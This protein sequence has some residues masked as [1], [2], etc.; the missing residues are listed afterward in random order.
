[1][2][3]VDAFS[4]YC[5]TYKLL[6]R[7]LTNPFQLSVVLLICENVQITQNKNL[8]INKVKNAF[9]LLHLKNRNLDLAFGKRG[10]QM[11]VTFRLEM[12]VHTDMGLMRFELD[13][14]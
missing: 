10:C 1:M 9:Q 8:Q 2:R 13:R 6:Q 11:A 14:N 3:A 5:L 4:K 7:I 12:A